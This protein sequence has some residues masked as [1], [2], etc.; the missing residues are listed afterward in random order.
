MD[1][2]VSIFGRVRQRHHQPFFDRPFDMEYFDQSP[3]NDRP[4]PTEQ[5]HFEPLA[6][7]HD[8]L[9]PR[10][11]WFYSLRVFQGKT[12][13]ISSYKSGKMTGPI[14]TGQ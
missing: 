6:V 14:R 12:K 11:G 9:L 5:V 10:T 8:C 2:I 13:D 3:P 7:Y 4:G 1:N